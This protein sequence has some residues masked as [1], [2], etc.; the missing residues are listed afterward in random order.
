M[1]TYITLYKWTDQGIKNVKES[2][3]RIKAAVK[4]VEV[5]G[6]KVLGIYITMGKYDL[7]AISEAPNDETVAAFLLGQGM[8]GN[9]RTTT[10]RAFTEDQFADILKKLP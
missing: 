7:V 1:P 6:G 4:A 8:L 9:V 5:A 3:D 2:P 10:L